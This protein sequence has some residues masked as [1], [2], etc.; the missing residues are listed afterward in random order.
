MQGIL[1]KSHGGFYFVQSGQTVYVCSP[2]G[3][4][5]QQLKDAPLGLIVGDN[6][7]IAPLNEQMAG[8]EAT[9]NGAPAELPKATI[10][11]HLPRKNYLIRPKIANVDQC[12]I[13]LAAKHPKPDFLLTD[14]MLVALLAAD[15]K[16]VI[17]LNKIDQPGADELLERLAPY[18]AAGIP[19][20][21]ISAAT[22]QGIAP[23]TQLLNGRIS[24]V[25]GQSGVGKST[26][27]NLLLKLAA[28][29]GRE[30][31]TGE[32]SHKLQRGRH[33]TRTVEL[34]PLANTNGW[35]ADTP[36]FSRLA[37]PDNI[38][39]QG[40]AGF[41][42]DFAPYANACRFDGCRHQNEP[43]CAVKQAVADGRLSEERHR[44]YLA[45]LQEAA[46]HKNY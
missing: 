22:Q 20:Y 25:A 18:K 13:V 29:P 44:R 42:P 4:L 40:L 26:L 35:I 24:T 37:L 27:L 14:R 32:I 16:P 33:T 30:L 12:L 39:P 45:L 36:G 5:K 17:V 21:P 2:R 7:K 10:E 31:L 6:L 28:N 9:F 11:E 34:L 8:T 19:V 1:L 43:D 23:L 3:R 38:T 46:E 41:Y 15:I